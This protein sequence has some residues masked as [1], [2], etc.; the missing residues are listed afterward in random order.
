MLTHNGINSDRWYHIAVTFDGATYKLYFDGIEMDSK[1]GAVP[2]TNNY[3]FLIGAMN[4]SGNKT[5]NYF[6]GSLD[7]LRIW[8]ISLTNEQ[9]RQMMNQEIIKN[10]NNVD[11]AVIPLPIS[12][13]T[14]T[15]L[16]GYYRMNQ[17]TSDV[18]GGKLNG[19]GFVSGR[20]L[21]MTQPQEQTAPLPYTTRADDQDW[22]TDETW[23]KLSR[24]GIIQIA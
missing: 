23:T 21:K 1:N 14:W 8:N 12:G 3:K 6:N 2:I 19:T 7:E 11:G 20:L 4:K 17:G 13:L 24:Y 9:I 10:G 22:S 5:I 15:N 18:L 16:A